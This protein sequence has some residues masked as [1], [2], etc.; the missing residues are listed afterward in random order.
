MPPLKDPS[1]HILGTKGTGSMK[2]HFFSFP[3]SQITVQANR[4][5]L[6]HG[7]QYSPGHRGGTQP[8]HQGTLGWG[9]VGELATSC[10]P[11]LT[12]ACLPQRAPPLLARW[13]PFAA[14]AAANCVNIPMMRQQ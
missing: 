10:P 11:A 13:V 12:P 1:Y 5:G 7:N 4:G 9:W 3:S 2:Q 14:V 6:H 8:L